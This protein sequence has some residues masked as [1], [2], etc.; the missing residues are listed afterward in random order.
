MNQG[1]AWSQGPSEGP[2][3]SSILRAWKG[4][5]GQH[6][7]RSAWVTGLNQ[8]GW[9]PSPALTAPEAS[10]LF[11]AQTSVCLSE[12]WVGATAYCACQMLGSGGGPSRRAYL[13]VSSAAWASDNPFKLQVGK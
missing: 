12:K 4:P 9:G 1:H 3:R 2:G 13:G 8:W 7:T 6:A 11:T 5:E 10:R